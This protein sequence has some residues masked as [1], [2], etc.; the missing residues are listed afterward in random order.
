[1]ITAM[2]ST[3]T[4]V[5]R[6][7]PSVSS[8]YSSRQVGEHRGDR[9]QTHQ[10]QLADAQLGQE[11]ELFLLLR[12]PLLPGSPSCCPSAI[13]RARRCA[14]KAIKCRSMSKAFVK[15]DGDARRRARGARRPRCR[16]LEKITLR[17]A[18]YARLKAELRSWSRSSGPRWWDRGLGGVARRPLGERRLH[19][20][21][22][23]PARDRPAR[24]LPDQAAGERRGGQFGRARH[25]PGVFRRDG[26][27]CRARTARRAVTIVGV[28][29][30][31]PAQR[32]RVVGLADRQ[33]ADQGARGRHG[34]A[35]HAR[36]AKRNS[37]SWRSA[38]DEHRQGVPRVRGQGQRRRPRGRRD[39]RRA[40]SARSSPRWSRTSSCRWSAR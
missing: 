1:M 4:R 34:D 17:P 22:A 11:I 23:R 12:H 32:P 39:H 16:R 15:E 10:D 35:A 26:A 27:S 5:A 36:R 9:D 38:T 37:K 21:Q 6:L 33:G 8:T 30:V 20:R 7:T 14:C 31:D 28:D 25:R 18:G 2:P 13:L 24:A 29:E 3:A 40:R 19:L